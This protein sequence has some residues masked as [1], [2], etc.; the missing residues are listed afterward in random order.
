VV[1]PLPDET[2]TFL[3]M[4]SPDELRPGR[5][6]PDVYLEPVAPDDPL[7]RQTIL[8]VGAPYLW[9]SLGWTDE[10]WADWLASPRRM[11]W[12]I[13]RGGD[14]AGICELEAHPPDEVEIASFGLVPEHVGTG[15][16]GHALTLV[17]RQAWQLSHPELG[18]VRR[19]WLHTSSYDHPHAL[20]NYLRRGFR[21]YSAH[22]RQHGAAPPAGRPG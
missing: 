13:R 12:L 17:A 19:V 18:R 2:V 8:R 6:V 1:E 14:V 7:V 21:V 15:I 3:E 10:T 9:P 11:R 5:E 22:V 20:P 4:T 16:G